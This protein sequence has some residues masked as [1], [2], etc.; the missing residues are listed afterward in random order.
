[1]FSSIYSAITTGN[2]RWNELKVKEGLRYQWD[3][4]STYIHNPP[5][6]ADMKSGDIQNVKGARCL[7]FFG[8]SITTDYISPAGNIAITSPAA[9]YLTERGIQ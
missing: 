9:K 2:K 1:M 5:F 4:K 8:D 3:E 6:F 7:A